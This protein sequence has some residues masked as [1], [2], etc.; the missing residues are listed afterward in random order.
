MTVFD[1]RPRM[2]GQYALP[3][4]QYCSRALAA[5]T[6][7][8]SLGSLSRSGGSIRCATRG[9]RSAAQ[10]RS[11]RP[12]EAYPEPTFVGYVA[13]PHLADGFCGA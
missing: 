13:R 12:L 10:A 1:D 8:S 7:T 4:H 11:Y 5:A 3:N 9:R 2:P 6:R